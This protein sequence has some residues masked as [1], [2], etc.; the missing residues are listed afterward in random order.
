MLSAAGANPRNHK[1]FRSA[2][3]FPA[4][5]ACSDD[6]GARVGGVE[7]G[8][9]Q[10][11][12]VEEVPVVRVAAVVART[13]RERPFDLDLLARGCLGEEPLRRTVAK[14]REIGVI[15]PLVG[16][17]DD[18]VVAGLLERPEVERLVREQL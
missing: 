9:R 18:E 16:A 10:V 8:I 1:T 12:G 2:M 7:M 3:E 14:L 6:L 11:V 15:P 5:L 4:R 17:V 13:A